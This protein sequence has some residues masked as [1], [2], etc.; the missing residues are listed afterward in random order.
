MWYLGISI[1]V[2]LTTSYIKNFLSYVKDFERNVYP[3]LSINL[4]EKYSWFF[5]FLGKCKS[6]LFINICNVLILMD[7]MQFWFQ[8]SFHLLLTQ[9]PPHF[10]ILVLKNCCWSMYGKWL[11]SLLSSLFVIVLN[12]CIKLFI[13]RD[14]LLFIF[15]L[16]GLRIPV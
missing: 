1:L 16:L 3:A 9:A 6:L 11:F 15:T 2:Q 10:I 4:S 14:Y 8:L 5:N 7:T 12:I 13:F